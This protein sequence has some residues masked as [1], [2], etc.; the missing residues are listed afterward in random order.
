VEPVAPPLQP[1]AEAAPVPPPR[2][3]A[4]PVALENDP[5]AAVTALPYE[6]KIALFS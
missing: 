6:E 1:V 3:A 2:P 5:L 4:P